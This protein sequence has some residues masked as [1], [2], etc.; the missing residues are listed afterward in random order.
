MTDPAWVSRAVV[1]ALHVRLI[2][3]FGGDDGLRDM[4]LL[5]SALARPL[6]LHTYARPTLAELAASYAYGLVMNHPFVD[7]DQRIGFTTA[8]LFLEING[9]ALTASAWVPRSRPEP[10][11]G[12]ARDDGVGVRPTRASLAPRRGARR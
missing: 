4:G 1:L 2:A 9:C 6:H 7:G 8:G 5:E 3:E 10:V 12:F 11:E